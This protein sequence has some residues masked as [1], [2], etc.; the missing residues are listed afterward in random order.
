MNWSEG[1]ILNIV[2][3]ILL[4]NLSLINLDLALKKL[5]FNQVAADEFGHLVERQLRADSL[6]TADDGR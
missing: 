2:L 1:R 3:K 5:L 6:R 4:V